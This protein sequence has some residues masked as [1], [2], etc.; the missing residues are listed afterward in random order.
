VHFNH[1]YAEQDFYDINLRD[2]QAK[3]YL[4][5]LIGNKINPNDGVI[6]GLVIAKLNAKV[7]DIYIFVD[8]DW[9]NQIKNTNI[10]WG[11]D[12][13]NKATLKEK[14]FDFSKSNNGVY[15]DI[16]R[17]ITWKNY[18]PVNGGILVGDVNKNTPFGNPDEITSTFIYMR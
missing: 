6:N 1:A 11:D 10:V 8:E 3:N 5:M 14:K 15:Y 9:K 7:Y 16:V 13:S 2:N 18:N 17:S 4:R 12:F